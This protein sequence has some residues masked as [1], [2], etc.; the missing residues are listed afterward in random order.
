MNDANM[1]SEGLIPQDWFLF[2]PFVSFVEVKRFLGFDPRKSAQSTPVRCSASARKRVIPVP[3]HFQ[4]SSDSF[5]SFSSAGIRYSSSTQAPRSIIRQ[6][7]EQNGREVLF[8]HST[9]LPQ[10]GHFIFLG[11][12]A[13]ISL[14]KKSV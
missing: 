1:K 3:L 7:S 2:V 5:S 9:A 10:V 14:C 8:S 11:E 4:E 6:R 12:F 13:A